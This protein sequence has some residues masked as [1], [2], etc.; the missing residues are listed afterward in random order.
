MKKRMISLLLVV[1]L[2]LGL[3]PV[4]AMATFSD[5]KGHWAE[6]A[7]ERWEDVEIVNGRSDGRFHPDDRMTR[8]EVA[9]VMSKLFDYAESAETQFSDVASDAWYAGAI[10]KCAAAGVLTGDGDGMRPED[11]VTRQEAI[12]MLGRAFG[13]ADAASGAEKFSDAADIAAWALPQ[14]NAMAA[15]GYVQGDEGRFMPGR[16]ITRAEIMTI[17]DNMV[18]DYINASGTYTVTGGDFVIVTA[19]GVTIVKDAFTGRIIKGSHGDY[20]EGSVP[21]PTESTTPSGGSSSGSSSGGG[22]QPNNVASAVTGTYVGREQENGLIKFSN[23]TYATAERW[24][25]PEPVPASRKTIQANDEM[26]TVSV[27][28]R[29]PGAPQNENIL[30]LDLY[31]NP[32]GKRANKGVFVWNTCGGGTA[33]NSNSFDPTRMLLENPD[34]IVVVTNIR[35]SYF[36]CID[37]SVFPDYE[38]NRDTYQYSNNLMRLDYLASLKWVNQNISAFG[39]DP[40]NVTLGGQ[41]A[42]AAN[43]SSMLLM[44]EAL[45]YFDKVIMESGVAIDRISLAT[46]EESRNAAEIFKKSTGA[47]TLEEALTLEPQKL[48]DAQAELTKNCIGAYLPDSQSKTF[49]TVVDNVVIPEDYWSVI[50]RAAEQGVKILVGSTNG[51]YDRDLAGK[52]AN[53]ALEAIVSA[54]WGKLD[55]ARGGVENASEII[56]GYVERNEQYSRDTITAYKDLKNDI[57]QKVSAT[58]IAEAFSECSTAYL[59]SY[60]WFTE[61]E[62]GLR[63]IHGSEK[64]ALYPSNNSVPAALAKAM[65]SA[66]ASFILYGDPNTKNA[67]F[68][69]ANVEWKP[70]NTTDKWIMVFDETMRLDA[71][72]RVEDIESLMPLFVEYRYLRDN[73][74]GAPSG[75]YVGTV[76]EETGVVAYKGV[77]FATNERFQAPEVVPE[78]NQV[79]WATEYGPAS[80]SGDPEALNLVVYVN[81][82][83]TNPYKSVFMWQYGSAQNG[84]TTSRTNWSNFVAENPDIIVVTPNHRGGFWGSVDLSGLE[85]YEA[86]E[87]TYKYSNNLARLDLLAC[88]KWINQNIAAFGGNPDDVTI[89]GQS[90][91]SNNCTCLLLM[92]EAHPYFQKAIM[93]SSFSVDISLQPLEDAKFVSGKFFE[94]LGVSRVD[95]LLACTDE[96]INAA[97]QAVSSGSVSGSTAFANLECKMF[98]PVIDGVVIPKDY[99]EKLLDGGLEGI[100]CVFG[101]NEGEYDQQ[102]LKNGERLSDEAALDFTIAQN[103]GKLDSERGWNKENA[104]TIIREFYEHNA[105]YGRDDYTAAKDLKND[106]YL[107]IG[108]LMYAEAA[109]RYTD[110]YLYYNQ[111]D[112]TPPDTELDDDRRSAHGSEIEVINRDWDRFATLF[113]MDPE[114]RQTA[115]TIS[116]I[117]AS[118]ILTGNPNGEKLDATWET[119]DHESQN[120]LVIC[121]EPELVG[122]VR[123]KDVDLLMP[124]FREY[125]LL[126]AALEEQPEGVVSKPGAYSGYSEAEYDGY[127]RYSVYV[128]VSDGT[129]LA[130]DYCIPTQSGVEVGEALPVV[131]TYTPY[132]RQRAD[133]VTSAEW[134]TSYGYA[135]VS[136]DCRGMGAS[137]GTRDAANSPQEAQ[138]GADIVAWIKDQNWCDGKLGTIGSSYVGQ[139]Q[140]AILSKSQ[141]VDASVIGCTDY[142]KYDGWIRGGI[143]RAFGSMPDTNWEA[144]GGT[145]TVDSMVATTPAVDEDTDKTMLREAI[146]QH[147]ANGLQIPMFQRLLWRDSYS[148][149]V[150]GAYWNLVSASTNKET[151]NASGSAIYLMGGLYDVFRRD[152]FVIYENLTTP[153]KMTIGPWYHTKAKVDPNWEI[154][155]LR[156]FD[157]WLKGIDNGIMDED[158]IYLKTANRAEN[159]GYRW[160]TEWPV[161]AGSRTAMYLSGT[162]ALSLTTE[163]TEYETYVDYDVVYGIATG[164]ESASSADVDAKG[165]CFTTEPFAEDFEITGHAMAHINFEM[166]SDETDID[167]FVTV[168]DYDPETGE[169]F[170]FDDGH[171][172]ASLRGTEEAPY[173]FLGL[174]WH[175]ADEAGAAPITTGEVYE[176]EI[177]L[178]PTSYIVP[179][180]HCLRVTISNSMD[181]FY[182]LGRSAFEADP[183]CETPSIRLYTGG[184]NASYMEL[185]DLYASAS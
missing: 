144:I 58:M 98:S 111:F 157:Y 82:K 68:E 101:S 38:A 169:S 67:S 88:L 20:V 56:Q 87:E 147:V 106:L 177:D 76:D 132:G 164:V 75:T 103:W 160:Q 171:L 115:E 165:L 119:F 107:R 22:H 123:Q 7:I 109:S 5:V 181:R 54:N 142:N 126:K 90:S 28:S 135:F 4:T 16:D 77:L 49:T 39:G 148:E 133:C 145:V 124:L 19:G 79:V 130:V 162:D 31:V 151:I 110:V 155:Q 167:F 184:E 6:A 44:E 127:Q 72:Q 80:T 65:R 73:V 99:Y 63:A 170:L 179:A 143:P 35:V 129:K 48:L 154:E 9:T 37:L 36:G 71:G 3:L 12:V 100:Q 66:W 104:Q 30:T 25:A 95:E 74:A 118:F 172:R 70:Y 102:Y 175:P 125:P 105:E 45:P 180:G 122:G 47:S 86:V 176:L 41:S 2:V 120:T 83:S 1:V 141:L 146:E 139:T 173:D 128:P 17:L 113:E 92:E 33:S 183:T 14:A 51:E 64:Q 62:Q 96:Q 60:E 32:D 150:D 40:E 152:T 57:N 166:L 29:A 78:C 13:M 50:E 27:Q 23:I 84:G 53:E 52:S 59:F 93:E 140:L 174:P 43:D 108:S 26:T 69:K 21:A 121:H 137:Y 136:A 85:G 159:N 81:P 10:G 116:N 168:S 112:I 117:W 97:K 46:M 8:A 24:Q 11:S 15:A 156:W 185:P 114:A 42:G 161:D 94:E 158:P 34:L 153:K 89:G 18:S 178:M 131:F 61:N 182:Y 91:G 138:D 55:P 163:K 134:F 149:E